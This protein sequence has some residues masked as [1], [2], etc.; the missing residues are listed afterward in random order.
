MHELLQRLLVVLHVVH[1]TK[2]WMGGGRGGRDDKES[3]KTSKN[4]TSDIT[5][6]LR[7]QKRFTPK[8]IRINSFD[9]QS[10]LH[11]KLHI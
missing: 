3:Q 6:F 9:T 8:Y 2:T 7:Y 11:T 5:E 4:R 1:L 10:I